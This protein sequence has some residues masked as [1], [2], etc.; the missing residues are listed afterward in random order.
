MGS[1]VKD[2]KVGIRQFSKNPGSMIIAVLAYAVG[3]GLVG[4]MLTMIFG[5]VRG[6]P[7]DIDFDSVKTLQWDPSTR[8]LWKNGAQGTFLHYPDFRELH[9]RQEAFTALAA[10]QGA[11]FSVIIDKYA[12]RFQGSQVTADYFEAL[13]VRPEI[14]HFFV[15]GDDLPTA[16]RKT[17]L[18]YNFWKNNFEGRSSI[19]GEY[20]T[21]D[22][23]PTIVIGVAR[24]G[25]GFPSNGNLWTNIRLDH[26]A[27]N[28]GERDGYLVHGILKP[29]TTATSALA[30][31]NTIARQFE[32]EHPDTNTGYIA[33]ELDPVS[34]LYIGDDLHLMM[35]LMLACAFL[36]LFIACMN[37]ANLTLARVS[38][39]M[40]ELAIR[41]SLG[42]NRKRLIFQMMTEG[43]SIAFLGGIGGILIALWTSTSI[44]SW[45]K[46]GDLDIPSWMNMD[47]DFEV[48]ATLC[49][50]TL[51]AS[52]VASIMPALRASRTDMNDILKDNSRG[53]TGL[54]IGRFSKFLTF[55]QLCASCGILIATSSLVS[56][57][58]STSIFEPYYDPSGM[59]SA[60]FILPDDYRGGDQRADAIDHLQALME[61]NDALEGVGFT[62]ANDMVFN[63]NSRWDVRGVELEED[64]GFTRGRQEI[65]SDNYF[66]LLGVPILYGR[67]FEPTDR[68][69]NALKV[70]IVD[71]IFAN[72]LWPDPNQSALGQQIRDVWTDDT[73]WLTIV[74]IVPDTKMAGPGASPEEQI[75]GV[76][77]SLG[78]MP[79][80][81]MTVFAK[82]K[83]DPLVQAQHIRAVLHSEDERIALYRINT[84]EQAIEDRNFFSLFYRNMFG[85]FGAAA[86]ALASIGVYGVISFSVRQRF[87]EFGIRR[88]LGASDAVIMGHVLKI[89]GVQIGIGIALGIVLGWGLVGVLS[90]GVGNI[91]VTPMNYIVPTTVLIAISALA[92]FTPVR[93]VLKASLADSL[94]DE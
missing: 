12:E 81:D 40:K 79:R 25:F 21:V 41:S 74:G 19:I 35:R 26:L 13:G 70:C 42:G 56:T 82:T 80:S 91:V 50:V 14:G 73:P 57:A 87:Q 49:I 48:I 16:Q 4:L 76:Y 88:A 77:N 15:E 92:V 83:G 33:F 53:S 36:V 85:M 3:L 34:L 29:N 62:T 2:L 89:G 68:G 27:M 32:Q 84:V 1:F 22:G 44:W 5:V 55:I 94:R 65:V 24:E 59:M 10:S 6:H 67:S 86:L 18:S 66:E 78:V 8:H 47:L 75:G 43:L 64:D 17:V 93:Q 9:N 20:L 30:S 71:E 7:K 45:A 90:E 46:K 61:N 11:S 28:R 72:R 23:E 51:F 54:K 63:W 69:P 39:R 37:V 58:N 60:R 31:L 52:V 38:S